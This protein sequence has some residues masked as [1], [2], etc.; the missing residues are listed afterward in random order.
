[1]AKLSA[2]MFR[3]VN[4]FSTTILYQVLTTKQESDIKNAEQQLAGNKENKEPHPKKCR[5]IHT[6]A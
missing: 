2:K 6:N 1:M 3:F 5:H 4:N